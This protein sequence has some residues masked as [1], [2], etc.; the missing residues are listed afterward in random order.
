[1]KMPISKKHK[2][3]REYMRDPVLK[4]YY[5]FF[6]DLRDSGN[7]IKLAPGKLR[8]KYKIPRNEALFIFDLWN[9]RNDLINGDNNND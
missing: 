2:T 8:D 7:E 5:S 3:L 6:N 4:E 9:A 1:M